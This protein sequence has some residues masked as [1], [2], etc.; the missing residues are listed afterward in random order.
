MMMLDEQ[1]IRHAVRPTGRN[2]DVTLVAY[3]TDSGLIKELSYSNYDH[4][5]YVTVGGR[6]KFRG[7]VHDTAFNYFCEVAA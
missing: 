7:D 2:Q 6:E 1:R 5:F 3:K 4:C